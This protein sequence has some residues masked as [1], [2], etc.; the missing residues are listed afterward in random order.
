M[1]AWEQGDP[2]AIMP[3]PPP[4]SCMVPVPH[5]ALWDL[6]MQTNSGTRGPLMILLEQ[7]IWMP[8]DEY[9]RPLHA[10]SD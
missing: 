6:H 7:M 1:L 9:F 3:A 5:L 4:L 8:N 2:L 10:R